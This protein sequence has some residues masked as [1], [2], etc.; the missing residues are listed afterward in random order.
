MSNVAVKN[1]SSGWGIKFF[2]ALILWA[3][4]K[5]KFNFLIL[6][7][8]CAIFYVRISVSIKQKKN[9]SSYFSHSFEVSHMKAIPKKRVFIVA[10]IKY[11]KFLFLL[12]RYNIFYCRSCIMP[13][14]PIAEAFVPL[15]QIF[16]SPF[17]NFQ[18]LQ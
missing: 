2:C 11:F 16:F 12:H 15:S 1:G 14:K 3:W 4:G 18:I 7:D 8:K 9:P 17:S 10:E 13:P 6:G 5:K